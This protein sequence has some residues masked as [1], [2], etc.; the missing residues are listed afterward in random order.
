M[1]RYLIA[2]ALVG[3]AAAIAYVVQRQRPDPPTQRSW[4]I[5][6]QLDRSDFTAPDT[7]WLVVIFSS[8]ACGACASVVA[9]AIPLVS[10]EVAVQEVE[11]ARHGDLHERYRID[12]VPTLVVADARGVVRASFVGEVSTAELWSVLA[13]LR[14]NS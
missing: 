14:E 7:A 2:F 3:M 6:S 9:K 12:A 13:D 11:L 8:A 5:P 10:D 4:S 1:S